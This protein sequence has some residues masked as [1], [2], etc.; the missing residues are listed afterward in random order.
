T[1]QRVQTHY[2]HFLRWR[3]Y[4]IGTQAS[5]P[6]VAHAP[7][8]DRTD[9]I[10]ANDEL[11]K[12]LAWMGGGD[13][14]SWFRNQLGFYSGGLFDMGAATLARLL[15]VGAG[16]VGGPVARVVFADLPGGPIALLEPG[17]GAARNMFY[18]S[19]VAAA[20]MEAYKSKWA[21]W[22]QVKKAWDEG[23]RAPSPAICD[24]FENDVHDSRA[25]FKPFGDDDDVW[26]KRQ[27]ERIKTLLAREQA[28]KMAAAPGAAL[29]QAAPLTVGGTGVLGAALDRP[30][31]LSAGE[32]EEL[33]IYRRKLA[34][35]GKREGDLSPELLPT[36]SGGRENF[37]LWGYLRWRTV[38]RDR[39]MDYR[40]DYP[41][42][43][44]ADRGRLKSRKSELERTI[45]NLS[46]QA[47]SAQRPYS[48]SMSMPPPETMGQ[49]LGLHQALTVAE[50][51]LEAIECFL[52]ELPADTWW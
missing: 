35:H 22:R 4:R 18:G 20:I 40:H 42:L 14:V 30:A 36:Q 39:Y 45:K 28:Y 10:G 2:A 38:Y 33:A 23:T 21:Q 17:F 27:Q 50:K 1:K 48:Q 9:L 31:P 34:A 19:A 29:M 3:R 26:E 51:E 16:G 25:W 8:Q 11:N 12:E 37:V 44:Q 5:L 32:K 6:C 41:A 24:L 15:G 43:A 46:A 52:A 49:L 7:R 13:G 47:D